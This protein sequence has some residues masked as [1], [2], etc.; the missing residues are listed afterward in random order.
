MRPMVGGTRISVNRAESVPKQ[1]QPIYDQIVAIT[2]AFCHQHLND[3][4]ALM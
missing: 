4:Y 2:D 3:E 1:M